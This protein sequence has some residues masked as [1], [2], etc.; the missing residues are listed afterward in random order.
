MA[1]GRL[2]LPVGRLDITDTVTSAVAGTRLHLPDEPL[3]LCRAKTL[4]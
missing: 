3:T 1:P 4:A 2:P